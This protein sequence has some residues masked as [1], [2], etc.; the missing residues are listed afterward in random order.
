M[1]FFDNNRLLAG[2]AGFLI[3]APLLWLCAE[4]GAA[5]RER[6]ANV[7]R[8]LRASSILI[9]TGALWWPGH[10]AAERDPFAGSSVGI[11]IVGAMLA[12]TLAFLASATAGAATRKTLPSFVG[13][14]AV[15][16]LVAYAH[17]LFAA[18][19]VV[20]AAMLGVSWAPLLAVGV[21][22]VALVALHVDGLGGKRAALAR[23]GAAAAGALTLAFATTS[24]TS[25]SIVGAAAVTECLLMLAL[26]AMAAVLLHTL[27]QSNVRDGPATRRSVTPPP[28]VDSLTQL[29]TRV[30]FEDRL[31]AAATKCDASGSRLA[32]LFIDLD[33]FKPVNDTYGHSI[34]DLVLEQVGQRLKSM[35][36]GRD[37]VA[38]VGGDEFLLLLSNV[39]TQE[40]VAQV[41]TRLIDGLSLPYAVDGREVMI[42]CSVGIA[43][44]PDGC[45]HQKLIARADAAMYSSKRAGGSNHCFYSPAMDADAEAQFDLLRDLRKALANNELELFYQP[46][47]DATSG[48]V[49]AVEA[50][51]RW[52]HPT[53]GTLLP[54]VFVPIAER[55]GLIGAIG[56]WVIEDACRQSR[57]W[58]DKGLR[59]R[60]AIN[61]SAH[62]MRQDDIVERITG[63]LEHYRIHPSL[64]TCE[65]TESAA[66]EDTKM[67]QATF[68]RLGELGVH[69]SIDDFGTGYSSLAYLR[70]L[71]AEELKIDRS[72]IMDLEHSADAR[73]V[74]DAVTKLA[75]A[76][77]LKVVAEGVENQR[78]QQI[79]ESM[80]IDELQGF[81]FAKPMS[82]RALLLWA[83]ND[84]SE[85]AVFKPSLFSE[86]RSSEE[87][88]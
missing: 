25:T 78:Q 45:S 81:L 53:R 31:A 86:T 37:V 85:S 4:I 23:L 88:A 49:T 59:M 5:A 55:S 14:G 18:P 21:L 1:D 12:A 42:S 58:R 79:L 29:P 36:R 40:S 30:Y 67:T 7:A 28:T 52:K 60:V 39:A 19:G 68:R 3:S 43:L 44:Y 77:G 47:M 26:I 71:P 24:A 74:V 33:G 54:G 87:I 80:H 61:L 2:I 65:I 34:G 46:K 73:A 22:S 38:R 64:I 72:F 82:G 15:T 75:H 13:L 17:S 8:R 62:Q 76:L 20:R 11:A 16:L 63:A 32:L 66:M 48:K 27:G 84:R 83:M 56:N 6:S 51:L 41:A 9:G 35:S 57:A 50:L 70:K 10:V 69:L